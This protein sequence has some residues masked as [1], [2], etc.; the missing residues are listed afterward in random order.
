MKSLETL[1][2][3]REVMPTAA[4]SLLVVVVAIVSRMGDAR[5]SLTGEVAAIE[6]ILR[7]AAEGLEEMML[8]NCVIDKDIS[9][10]GMQACKPWRK[11]L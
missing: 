10:G 3:V 6:D 1:T 9:F 2:E 8:V 5:Y 11:N 7:C 4:K